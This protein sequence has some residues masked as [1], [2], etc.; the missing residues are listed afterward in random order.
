MNDTHV[1]LLV[2]D[3]CTKSDLFSGKSLAETKRLLE[4]DGMMIS[5]K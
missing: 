1:Q 4:G 2:I 3:E 5:N